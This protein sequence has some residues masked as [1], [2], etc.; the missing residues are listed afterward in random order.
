MKK[1]KITVLGSYNTDITVNVPHLPK[2]GETVIGTS[3]KFNPGGKGSN[4]AV[5]AHMAGADV[6]F[7]AKVG[8]DGMEKTGFDLY[9]KIGL[10]T[11]DTI[12]DETVSTG[13]ATIE[14]DDVTAQNRI[15][16]IPGA[17]GALTA[18]DVR[19]R[20]DLIASSDILLLQLETS[21][22]SI[23]EAVR[24]A[25][26]HGVTVVL[27]PAP[28]SDVVFDI[29]KDVDIITPNET[30]A[31]LI[32]PGHDGNFQWAAS[33]IIGMGCDN[34]IITVGSQG[35]Y[36]KG[37]KGEFVV[38]AKKVKAVDTTGAGDAFNGALCTALAEGCKMKDAMTF[39]SAFASLSV[40]RPGAAS[41]MPTREE[42]ERFMKD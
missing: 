36:Y 25:K 30:E 3:M 32:A 14:V 35:S 27:N 26:A 5:A 39:A 38:P 11:D 1:A 42:T 33:D 10:R 21:R 17:N 8:C 12:K 9:E 24:I 29:I 22:E 15:V 7:I 2:D 37:I 4:Q 23:I 19:K 34:V 16:V 13:I 18:Q 41:S 20:E 31:E 28:F 40:T 6:T